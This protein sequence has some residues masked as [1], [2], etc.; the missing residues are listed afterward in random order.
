MKTRRTLVLGVGSAAC[1]LPFRA[2]L[3]QS[4]PKRIGV[5][6][7]GRA[8]LAGKPHAFVLGMRE[9]GYVEG[10]DFV[11]EWRFAEG[12]Y[13]RLGPFADELVRLP[14]D[15]IVALNTRGA[16][17]AQRATKT[18]PIV[19]ASISDPLGSGLVPNLAHPGGNTTGVSVGLDDTVTKHLELMRTTLPRFSRVGVLINPDNPL[20]ERPLARLQE[21]A[22]ASSTEVVPV[23]ARNVDEI[24]TGFASLRASATSGVVVFDDSL[25]IGHG[26]E[27]ARRGSA[28]RP[29]YHRRQPGVRGLGP[30]VQL[31]RP[32]QRAVW[33]CG[34]LRRQDFSRRPARRP[35]GGAADAVL[36]RHQSQDGTGARTHAA[37]RALLASGCGGG[38]GRSDP[39]G[40]HRG[41][42]R[43]R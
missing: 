12:R 6:S 31:R 35:S 41:V 23:F 1:V 2:T 36:L 42:T 32:D 4:K 39:R 7:G 27:L 8:P 3:A 10:R 16:L 19:F 30:A 18:I 13:E 34:L 21:A 5:I 29:A 37:G 38:I 9:I 14:V 15:V 26:R 20:F 43:C 40:L 22:K 33:A 17:E 25:F 11:I 28:L 24:A